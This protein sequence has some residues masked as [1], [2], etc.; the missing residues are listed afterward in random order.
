MQ[1]G[2]RDDKLTVVRLNGDVWETVGIPGFT[3]G[4]VG[5]VT[6]AVTETGIPYV[7]FVDA[8]NGHKV[9]V[10]KVSFDP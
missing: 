2:T 8:L 4:Q 1:D 3:E 9:T 6:I 5:S 7:G 10:L